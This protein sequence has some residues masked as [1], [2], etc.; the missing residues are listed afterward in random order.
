MA[1]PLSPK[2]LQLVS[3][4]LA[5]RELVGFRQVVPAAAK[6]PASRSFAK[7]GASKAGVIKPPV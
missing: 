5:R 4:K 3:E 7:L 6:P 2:P 1:R